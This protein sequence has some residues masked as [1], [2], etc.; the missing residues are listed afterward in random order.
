LATKYSLVDRFGDPNYSGNHRKNMM[1][2][3]EESLKRLDTDTIDLLWLHAWDFT[4]PVDEVLRGLNDLIAQGKVHYIGISDT[5]AWIVAQANTIAELRGWNAFVG[6][7]VEYSLLQRTV[8]RDL[9]PMAKQFD[10][11]VTPWAPLA[12]GALTGKYI[13]P[14]SEEGR[15]KEDSKRRSEWA[16]KIVKVLVDEAKQ[17]GVSPAQ[18]ALKWVME[19]GDLIIP[20][21]GARKVNQLEDSLKA[22][23]V[24]IPTETMQKLN[25]ASAI[26][27]GFLHDFLGQKGIDENLFGGIRDKILNHRI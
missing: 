22:I 25:E 23:E 21:V 26:E 5:P 8:E 4:T 3:V 10:L 20:I 12:G 6:L 24:E 15:V 11:A 27:L 9:I 7:Q 1:R 2:S 17:I 16:N 14:N 13:L 19:Q 18:L